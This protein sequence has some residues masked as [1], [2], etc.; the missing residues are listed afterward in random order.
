MRHSSCFL[1]GGIDMTTWT[2]EINAMIRA[3]MGNPG[4]TLELAVLALLS[5]IACTVIVMLGSKFTRMG[6]VEVNRSVLTVLIGCAV[7]LA[8]AVA[9]R[10][11]VEP[12]MES[13]ELARFVAPA[14]AVL[15]VLVIVVPL[16]CLLQKG[17]YFKALPPVI[18]GILAGAL[19]VI[20]VGAWFGAA[21]SGSKRLDKTRKRK[22]EIEN[23]IRLSPSTS[24]QK[25]T[26]I[27]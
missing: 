2:S 16:L 25:I 4:S 24:A 6:V 12:Q 11:Y 3:A 10:L 13:S 5:L 26:E 7:A 9:A 17:N 1:L 21:K 14:A 20:L 8:A 22:Q 23:F 19:I 27:A 15:A 18:L